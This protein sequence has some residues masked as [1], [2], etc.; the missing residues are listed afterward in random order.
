MNAIIIIIII[1]DDVV[2]VVVCCWQ[3]EGAA[4]EDGRTPSIWDTF[5]HAGTPR[6]FCSYLFFS[7]VLLIIDW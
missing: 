6:S 4:N 2:V 3:V 1:I 5:A 7:T